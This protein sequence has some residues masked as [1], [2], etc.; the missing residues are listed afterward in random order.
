M[1]D[2]QNTIT[3]SLFPICTVVSEILFWK[4]A[5]QK[6][7]MPVVAI[8]FCFRFPSSLGALFLSTTN[9]T[10]NMNFLHQ[11]I[12]IGY[13]YTGSIYRVICGTRSV[14]RSDKVKNILAIIFC[15]AWFQLTM[16]FPR[17]KKL[18]TKR[19]TVRSWKSFNTM[20]MTSR[21]RWPT[22][23]CGPNMVSV[24]STV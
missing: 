5:N 16:L 11:F 2:L 10:M 14:R 19:H 9:L 24:G 22:S 4:L 20:K 8:F 18:D 23:T 1:E 6:Q 17:R 12:W 13:M 15:K 7:K 3:T 21:T